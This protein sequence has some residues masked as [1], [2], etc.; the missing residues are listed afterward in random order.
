MRRSGITALVLALVLAGALG[1]WAGRTVLE[2]PDD[3]LAAPE[4]SLVEAREG[5]VGRELSLRARAEWVRGAQLSSATGGVVTEVFIADGEL[6]QSGDR[7]ISLDLRP[8]TV[9]EGDI[10]MFR[11]LSADVI[12]RDVSQLQAFLTQQGHEVGADADGD[13]GPGTTSAVQDWQQQVGYEVTGTVQPGDVVFMPELPARVEVDPD[14]RVGAAIG[15]GQPLLHVL[16]QVPRFDIELP[17][18]QAALLAPGQAVSIQAE[19]EQWEAV[20]AT[21]GIESADGELTARL[22][23]VDGAQTIC[24]ES[25]ALIPPGRRELFPSQVT[26][27]PEQQGIVVP[28]SAIVTTADGQQGVVDAEGSTLGVRVLASGQG[29]SLVKGLDAGTL[30]RAPGLVPEQDS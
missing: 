16:A 30:V 9:A 19:E 14:A 24:G 7:A 12:G 13:F 1:W 3:V 17:E 23:V 15:P 18:G 11:E 10:P 25:C 8:V 5:S 20:V 22:E 27:V 2:P 26:I 4:Y 29:L 6:V 21:V 28:S